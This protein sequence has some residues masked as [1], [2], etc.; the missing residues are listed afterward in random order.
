MQRKKKTPPHTKCG[1]RGHAV[2][3][4][5]VR[6]SSLA[7]SPSS[8]SLSSSSSLSPCSPPPCCL[9]MLPFLVPW[10]PC[11]LVWSS[12]PPSFCGCLRPRTPHSASGCSQ[13][14]RRV[15]GRASRPVPVVLICRAFIVGLHPPITV[16]VVCPFVVGVG[17]VLSRS[18]VFVVVAP[19][20]FRYCALSPSSPYHFLVS[21]PRAAARG[22]GVLVAVVLVFASPSIPVPA[23]VIGRCPIFCCPDP[24]STPQAGACSGGVCAYAVLVPSCGK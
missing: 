20:P 3:P 8:A 2:P 17:V 13:R 23:I 6:M 4:I 15:L 12:S 21:T 16:V 5:L 10:L 1:G 19:L 14:R 7:F 11:G 24:L 22:G 18:V 9:P